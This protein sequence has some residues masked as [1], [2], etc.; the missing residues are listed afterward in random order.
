ML[1]VRSTMARERRNWE[2]A[3][4]IDDDKIKES[5]PAAAAPDPVAENK[6]ESSTLHAVPGR[7]DD[8]V[9]HEKPD[10]VD[11]SESPRLSGGTNV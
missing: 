1:W 3:A 8:T 2:E 10:I 9:K 5:A 4:P 6:S 7:Q 11:G